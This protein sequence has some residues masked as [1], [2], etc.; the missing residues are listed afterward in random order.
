MNVL[1]ASV[2]SRNSGLLIDTN[3]LVL[4]T[5]GSVN[6]SRIEN[7]KRTCQYNVRDYGLLLR[8]I[9]KIT[10]L[11]TVAHVMAEV[12]NLIDL[13]GR[14]QSLA[15]HVLKEM[16]SILQEP[17][18]PSVRAAHSSLYEHH[19]L[20]DTAIAAVAL[21]YKCTV[22]TADLDLYIEL[23]RQGIPAINF[24]RL[25]AHEWGLRADKG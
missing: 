21:E 25:R 12:S 10:P 16:L 15:R 3:L 8:V 19:G 13:S 17:E 20:A 2:S 4:Y 1:D 7:F 24:N 11:Y 5:V 6:R 14:E 23:T 9:Q 22:L 18:M